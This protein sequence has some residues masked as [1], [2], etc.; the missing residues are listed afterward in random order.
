LAGLVDERIALVLALDG[1]KA[2]VVDRTLARFGLGIGPAAHP[3]QGGQAGVEEDPVQIRH[4]EPETAALSAAEEDAVLSLGELD[5]LHIVS[6]AV[7][8]A[9]APLLVGIL[10][11]LAG[12]P[13]GR[14][15]QQRRSLGRRR[16]PP[17]GPLA[18]TRRTRAPS[19]LSLFSKAS[20]PRSRW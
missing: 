20:Y 4:V 5:H 11:S 8:G 14:L 18:C 9:A 13:P 2:H 6:R 17:H 15:P 7:H 12:P 1:Q 19:D 16:A 10:G 3:L